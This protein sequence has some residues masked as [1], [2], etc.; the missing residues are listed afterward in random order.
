MFKILLAMRASDN[1][2]K[3]QD[4]PSKAVLLVETGKR[5]KARTMQQTSASSSLTS[6]GSTAPVTLPITTAP[7]TSSSTYESQLE[8]LYLRLGEATEKLS[9]ANSAPTPQCESTKQEQKALARTVKHLGDQID[10][11]EDQGYQTL[12]TVSGSFDISGSSTT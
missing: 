1:V 6:L 5:K 8:S 12:D 11:L 4:D 10:A 2:Q 7:V 9:R 3:N